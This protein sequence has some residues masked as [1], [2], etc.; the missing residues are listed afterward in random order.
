M[1]FNSTKLS[2]HEKKFIC[3][4]VGVFNF[5]THELTNLQTPAFAGEV[6]L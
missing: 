6:F 1:P 2:K 4:K 5:E 3:L